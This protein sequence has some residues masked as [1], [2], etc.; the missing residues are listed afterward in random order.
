MG[1][2][3]MMLPRYDRRMAV[4]KFSISFTPKLARRVRQAAKRCGKPVS[5]WLAEA[6]EEQL[7]FD[8]MDA[9]LD[10]YE[11]RHGPFSDEEMRASSERLGLPWPPDGQDRRAGS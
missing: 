10:D 6:A 1:D 11:R 8:A 5:A 2:K 9:F 3:T 7:R 4:Q